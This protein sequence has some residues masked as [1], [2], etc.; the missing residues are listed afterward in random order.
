M[1]PSSVLNFTRDVPVIDEYE[2][3]R[4]TIV[5][6]GAS[7]KEFTLTTSQGKAGD[8]GWWD[9]EAIGEPGPTCEQ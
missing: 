5:F 9:D 4:R 3:I 7:A 1:E 8:S 2:V 6:N